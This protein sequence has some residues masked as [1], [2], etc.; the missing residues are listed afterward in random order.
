MQ[1]NYLLSFIKKAKLCDKILFDFNFKHRLYMDGA[2]LVNLAWILRR[3][4]LQ[5]KFAKIS[6]VDETSGSGI[7]GKQLSINPFIFEHS[8]L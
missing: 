6:G 1:L 5:N 7:L 8:K 2:G 4:I 3:Y